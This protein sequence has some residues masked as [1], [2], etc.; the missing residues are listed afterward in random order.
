MR[1]NSEALRS[2]LLGFSHSR[3]PIISTELLRWPDPKQ[4]RSVLRRLD[5]EFQCDNM[6]RGWLGM[7]DAGGQPAL[8]LLTAEYDASFADLLDHRVSGVRPRDNV[9]VTWS[10][11]NRIGQG[12]ERLCSR[13]I[14]NEPGADYG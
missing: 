2:R 7:R 12:K 5:P 9:R 11:T 13:R 10:I 4:Y 3:V 8:M 1:S 14:S 6:G